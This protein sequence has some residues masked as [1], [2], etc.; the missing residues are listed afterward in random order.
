MRA[1]VFV[2]FTGLARF[3][4]IAGSIDHFFV[5]TATGFA[6]GATLVVSDIFFGKD[7]RF[8]LKTLVPGC[9]ST[10]KYARLESASLGDHL[11]RALFLSG[12]TIARVFAS[13][14]LSTLA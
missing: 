8:L 12:R 6:L 3:L 9:R 1:G 7:S 14:A 13:T 2:A 10:S 5:L 11:H 4:L